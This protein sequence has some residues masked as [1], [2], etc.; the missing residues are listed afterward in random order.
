MVI[1]FD[2]S[3]SNNCV[4]SGVLFVNLHVVV[5]RVSAFVFICSE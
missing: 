3:L 2:L 1:M 5:A 4:Y